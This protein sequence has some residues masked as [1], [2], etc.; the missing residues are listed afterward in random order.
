MFCKFE[1]LLDKS[2]ETKMKKHGSEANYSYHN[3]H[4]YYWNTCQKYYVLK[5]RRQ[6]IAPTQLT[7]YS[8]ALKSYSQPRR[9]ARRKGAGAVDMLMLGTFTWHRDASWHRVVYFALS[10]DIVLYK[11]RCQMTSVMSSDIGDANMSRYMFWAFML[12]NVHQTWIM[13]DYCSPT[14]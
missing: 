12:Y 5:W 8:D 2:W 7:F 1:F 4:Q 14:P 9:H 3:I 11:S 13:C 6:T 10:D